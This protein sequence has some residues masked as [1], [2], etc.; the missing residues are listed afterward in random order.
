MKFVLK[1]L[2]VK[3]CQHNHNFN[4]IYVGGFMHMQSL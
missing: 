2:P 4:S 1:G 3:T